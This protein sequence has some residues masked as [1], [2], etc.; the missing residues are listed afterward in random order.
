MPLLEVEVRNHDF[1]SNLARIFIPFSEKIPE[2]SECNQGHYY[3]DVN[4]SF[5]VREK[6]L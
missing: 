6:I 3:Q 1:S 4:D 5:R 2:S